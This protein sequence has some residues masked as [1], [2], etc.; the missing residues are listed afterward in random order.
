MRKVTLLAVSVFAFC[1]TSFAEESTVPA[2][3]A[4]PRFSIGAGY[5]Y[6]TDASLD[7]KLF[8]AANDSA[9]GILYNAGDKVSELN[10]DIDSGLFILN[11]EAYLVWRLYLDGSLA[12]GNFE[13]THQDSDWL[14]LLDSATWS[15]TESDADGSTTTWNVNSYL[16][17]VEEEDDK[18]YLDVSF[19]YFYYQDDI[20]HI[21]NT[22]II[23]SGWEVVNTPGPS[24][25]DSSD[26][27]TF[28][29]IRLGAR[30]KMRFHEKFAVKA[31]V[32]I[33]PWLYVENE[34]FW[35]LRD[36]LG[37]PPGLE[38][39]GEADGTA[40]DF[41]VGIEF[42]ITKNFIIEAGYKYIHL[43]SDNGDLDWDWIATS[44]IDFT[45]ED[46]WNVDADRGGF[47]AM[48]R[49]RI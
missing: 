6:T 41:D 5:W 21:R 19:G 44:G 9:V 10:N 12:L 8:A 37:Q 34:K 7:L 24:G 28:D 20:E 22:T 11:A 39:E 23:I 30:G 26:K 27:Y 18:G 35:N 17:I 33:V 40:F 38:I 43:D 47:Y 16:R 2:T 13:G 46:N 4:K 36:D 1:T 32:G 15:L 25:H 3:S 29:G 48:G 42:S 49:L 45:T 31:N 14:S